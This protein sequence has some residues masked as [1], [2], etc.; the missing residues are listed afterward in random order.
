M[1]FVAIAPVRLTRIRSGSF[2]AKYR[3]SLKS[4]TRVHSEA[5][6]PQVCRMQRNF[7][8]FE[9]FP[10]DTTVNPAKC[11]SSDWSHE[12]EMR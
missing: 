9:T 2:G 1:R 7:P 3:C 8:T 6:G 5:I 10:S 11:Y 12:A 4:P